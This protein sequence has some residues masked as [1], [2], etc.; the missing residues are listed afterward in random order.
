MGYLSGANNTGSSNLY[1]GNVGVNSES[2]TLRIGDPSD[3]DQS[4]QT[5]AYIAGIYDS[6][7]T[8]TPPFQAVCVDAN[9]TVFGTI[10]GMSCVISSLRFKDHIADMGDSSSKLFQL[11]PVTFFYKPQY[12]DGSHLPQYGLIAEEVAKV[13]PE[14]AVYDKEGQPYSVK[15]QLL[16]PMLLNELQKQH[17]AVSAQ[18]D[19]IQ[20]QQEQVNAQQQQIESLQKQN[21]EFQQRLSRL[22]SVIANK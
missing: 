20:T 7:A 11:R 1:I 6:T 3:L 13:Y 8:P 19:V 16:A 4:Y 17:A 5:A 12:D 10:P 14:M 18:Q 2:N 15:Y 21:A 22:E 9:G